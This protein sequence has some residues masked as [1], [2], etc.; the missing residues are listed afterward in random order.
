MKQ[1]QNSLFV[2]SLIGI[3]LLTG[4]GAVSE[5][6][7]TAQIP[8]PEVQNYAKIVLVTDSKA[9][10]FK[11][12]GCGDMLKQVTLSNENASID[13]ALKVLLETK[14]ASTFGAGLTTASALSGGY[15]SFKSAKKNLFNDVETFVVELKSNPTVGLTGACDTPR[16]KNQIIETVRVNAF[17]IPFMIRLD[18]S[19]KKWECLGNESGEC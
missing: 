7:S 14:D 16:F 9:D 13:T 11:E 5:P 6:T 12:V 2:G 19:D 10:S 4:C 17:G 18:E 1:L 8:A 3:L 15:F